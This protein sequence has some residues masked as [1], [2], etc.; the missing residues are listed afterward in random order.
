[1]VMS[2]SQWDALQ[3]R[4]PAEDRVLYADYLASQG[5]TNPPV[6]QAARGESGVIGAASIASQQKAMAA[7]APK[8]TPT[9]MDISSQRYTAAAKAAGLTPTQVSATSVTPKPV[10][11]TSRQDNGDGTFTVYYSDGTSKIVGTL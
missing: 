6:T 3:K 11:E 4:L 9:P 7:E 2:K 5:V 1:M 10:T 8:P